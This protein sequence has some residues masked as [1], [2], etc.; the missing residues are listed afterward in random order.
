MWLLTTEGFYSVIQW[1]DGRMC[2]RARRKADLTR[3]RKIVPALS[4]VEVSPG[5]DYRYR[6]FCTRDEWIAG[7][8]ALAATIDYG[9]FKSAADRKLGFNDPLARAYHSIWNTLARVQP[10]G[11][12]GFGTRKGYPAVPKGEKKAVDQAR[13]DDRKRDRVAFKPS[14]FT[15]RGL[16]RRITG[17]DDRLVCEECGYDEL[18]PATAIDTGREVYCRDWNACL[19]RSHKGGASSHDQLAL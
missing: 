7:A 1:H 8:S 19:R 15:P 14:V 3:L 5:K 11:P 10:G 12:Y 17:D 16:T 6:C 4:K 9:N 2:V 13:A 18:T